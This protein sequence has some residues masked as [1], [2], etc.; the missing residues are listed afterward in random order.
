MNA[1]TAGTPDA[2]PHLQVADAALLRS[3]AEEDAWERFL[4]A[5]SVEAFCHGWL[6]VT[7]V[8]AGATDG[9]V[10]LAGVDGKAFLPAAAWP[11]GKRDRTRLAEAVER[12]LEQRALVVVSPADG[13]SRLQVAQPI[14]LEGQVLG[15]VALE[16]DPCEERELQTLARDLSWGAGWLE[17]LL[18]RNLN[19][20]D[21]ETAHRLRQVFDLFS[22]SLEHVGFVPAATATVTELGTLLGCDRVALAV[23]SGR[24][25]RI[26][27]LSHTVSFEKNAEL[28]RHI[29]AAMEEAL[30][31]KAVLDWPAQKDDDA[32]V[33][34]AHEQLAQSQGAGGILSVPLMRSGEPVG[35]LCLER[36]RP[37]DEA[38]R[39]MVE[40]LAALLGPLVAVQQAADRGPLARL[41]DTLRSLWTRFFGPGHLV[42]KAAGALAVVLIVF[43]AILTGDYRVSATTTIEGAVQRSLAAPFEGYIRESTVR[44]GDLV[45]QGGVVARLD[46]RDLQLER[47]KVSSR[48]EQLVKQHREALAN[49]DRAQIRVIGS[50]IDQADAELQVVEEK[51]ARTEV[52]AP[53][54]GVVVS[55]DL[56]QKLGA[57]VQR[58]EVLFEVAPLQDY[59]VVLQV[60]ERDVR[61]LVEGQP[62]QLVLSAM[63]AERLAF[64]V[65]RITPVSTAEDG[66]NFFRV[67]ARLDKGFE[68]LRP[69]MEGVGKVD[70]GERRLI[71][72]WTRHLLD[73]LRLELWWLLP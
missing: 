21:A 2:R 10:V 70:I 58:G 40:A 17:A 71:W 42:W 13:D 66:R 68:R 20:R 26:K 44:P 11:D 12:A 5:T 3:V 60:D 25:L 67:E 27:A 46:D 48:R 56:S 4:G 62:G 6:A 39:E 28:A 24:R 14:M 30:D 53:F 37:F 51:L 33:R 8:R 23:G 55:G 15:A 47:L 41:R 9:I 22:A 64:R 69:G 18:R 31:Q 57:P 73:W 49:H 16:T 29:E 36:E 34:R 43:F 35:A 50:Q 1:A 54:D 72:I 63:P 19:T 38:S 32:H 59:R 45:K 61:D 65:A 7:C 52:R